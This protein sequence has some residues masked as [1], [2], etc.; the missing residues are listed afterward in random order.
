MRTENQ[1]T[2]LAQV[3]RKGVI[4]NLLSNAQSGTQVK[5][6]NVHYLLGVSSV[7]VEDSYI[8]LLCSKCIEKEPG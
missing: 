4:V 2:K 5:R 8:Q 3:L 1:E 7:D 6:R